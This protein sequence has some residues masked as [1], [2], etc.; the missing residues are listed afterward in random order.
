MVSKLGMR[1]EKLNWRTKCK[2]VLYENLVDMSKVARINSTAAINKPWGDWLIAS[3]RLRKR[4]VSS[5]VVK[6]ENPNR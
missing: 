2:I 1:N 5:Q 6:K 4:V 3:S